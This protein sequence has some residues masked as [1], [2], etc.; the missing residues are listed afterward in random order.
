MMAGNGACAYREKVLGFH[1]LLRT[2]TT[3]APIGSPHLGW[4]AV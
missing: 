4:S 2:I 1:K 3:P